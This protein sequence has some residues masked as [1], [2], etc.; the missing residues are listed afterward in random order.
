MIPAAMTAADRLPGVPAGVG[1][2]V[3]A[4]VM[5]LGLIAFPIAMGAIGDAVSLRWALLVIPVSAVLI[6]ALSPLLKPRAEQSAVS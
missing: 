6:L 2:T 5:R 4:W 1:L 3:T